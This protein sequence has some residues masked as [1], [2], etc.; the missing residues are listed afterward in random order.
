MAPEAKS[1]YFWWRSN[2][3]PRRQGPV[4]VWMYS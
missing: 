1:Q 3:F 2:A 4:N